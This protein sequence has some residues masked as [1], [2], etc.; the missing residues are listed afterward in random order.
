MRSI[1]PPTKDS[2]DG[3]LLAF[4]RLLS[5]SIEGTGSLCLSLVFFGVLTWLP[6]GCRLLAKA[7]TFTFQVR[8][9]ERQSCTKPVC[10]LYQKSK[11]I[12]RSPQHGL[13]LTTHCPEPG[14]M[15]STC[16]HGNWGSRERPKLVGVAPGTLPL[17][18]KS[19][20]PEHE[21]GNGKTIV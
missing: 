14:H 15:T 9:G 11:T 17:P 3:R 19:Q 20:F 21:R 13:P 7:L 5:H 8:A 6:H 18:T 2:G 12:P 1:F 4:Y 16:Y 10:V